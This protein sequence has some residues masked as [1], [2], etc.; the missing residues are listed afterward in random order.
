[1]A[2]G[3]G[4]KAFRPITANEF[5][6]VLDETRDASGPVVIVVPTIPHANLPGSGLWWD[7]AP[8]EASEQPWLAAARAEYNEGFETQRWHG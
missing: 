7:V 5:R 3:M 1:M 8:A 2:K 6:K 4:A